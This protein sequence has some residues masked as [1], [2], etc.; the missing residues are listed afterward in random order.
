MVL[1]VS[2]THYAI[3]GLGTATSIS[4]AVGTIS[5]RYNKAK[6]KV[7]TYV[8]DFIRGAIMF[9]FLSSLSYLF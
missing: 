5:N 6:N 9:I 7:S 4:T 2:Q 3:S 8:E 1:V